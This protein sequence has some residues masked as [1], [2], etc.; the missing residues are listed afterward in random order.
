M[1]TGNSTRA[2]LM[3]LGGGLLIGLAIGAI[4][5]FGLPTLN[6]VNAGVTAS[7]AGGTPAPAPIVGSPAPDFT[8]NNINGKLITLSG[9]KGKPVLINFWATWCAPCRTEMP[10]IEA[11]YQKYGADGFTVL[12]VDADEA[13]ADVTDYVKALDLSFEVLMDPGLE[14]TNLYRVRAFP[15]S[16]FVDRDGNISAF[17]IGAMSDS[18]LAD[19][20]SKILK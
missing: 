15:S 4:V 5:F 8:L 12:A 18:I 14:V 20:I 10:A 17:Q 6:T 2:T 1:E 9:L 13:L 19:N 11:A 7:P 16:F 3:I